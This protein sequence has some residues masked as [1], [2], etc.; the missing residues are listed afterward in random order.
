M[1]ELDATR[2]RIIS[3]ALIRAMNACPAP[4]L[5]TLNKQGFLYT[6]AMEIAR[7]VVR[8]LDHAG[9]QVKETSRRNLMELEDC[10]TEGLSLSN[11]SR[12]ASQNPQWIRKAREQTVLNICTVLGWYKVVLVRRNAR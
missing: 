3:E 2:K 1:D 5:W 6:P 7:L 9:W 11:C 4:Y 8:E 12:L 10:I